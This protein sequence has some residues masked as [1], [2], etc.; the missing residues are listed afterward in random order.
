MKKIKIAISSL[1]RLPRYHRIALISLSLATLGIFIWQPNLHK[2]G[3]ISNHSRTEIDMANDLLQPL[4]DLNSEPL[5][6][7]IDASD[8]EFVSPQDEL[9]KQLT[10]D[11]DAVH[12]HRVGNGETLGAIFEQYGLPITNMYELL[13]SNKSASNLHIGQTLEW[14]QNEEN[15]LTELR[16][17]RSAKLTD[18]YLWN[19]EKYQF[20]QSEEQGEIK[21][22][23][24]SGR[25]SSNFYNSSRAAGLTPGQIQTLAQALQWKFDFGREAR[26]GDKFAV[27]IER[28]FIDGKAVGRG[29]VTAIL[30]LNGNREITAVKH[31]DGRFYDDEG[32]SLNR[33]LNRYPLAKKYRISSSFNPRRKHPVTGR[34]SPHNGTDFATPIGTPVLASGD[35]VVVKARKHSLAGNYLVIKHGREYSTRYLHLHKLLVK[36]GDKVSMGQKI[37]LS[38]NTG[39]STGPHLHYELLKNNRPVNAMKVPLPQA[40]PITSRER[41]AFKSKAKKSISTLREQI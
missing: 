13:A 7:T 1:R 3:V 21:P 16:I 26:K 25:V 4:A 24:L 23:V 31:S 2:S 41:S 18:V 17:D 28:E 33:A 37:A 32:Q 5:G 34:I 10:A 40:E 39:R 19:G 36:A 9:E 35:G 8:P 15:R 12:S 27:E 30:Y 38:G 29:E 6:A 22:I 20:N 14:R 11:V